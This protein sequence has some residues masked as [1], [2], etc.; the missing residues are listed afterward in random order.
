LPELASPPAPPV[1]VF[2]A[3]PPV[4]SLPPCVIVA[5]LSWMTPTSPS[6]V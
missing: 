3:S 5:S 4:A 2:A 1:A 6:P